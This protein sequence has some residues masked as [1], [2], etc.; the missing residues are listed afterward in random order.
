M[1]LVIVGKRGFIGSALTEYVNKYKLRSYN[2]TVLCT[3]NEAPYLTHILR[4]TVLLSST[5]VLNPVND[6][7][8]HKVAMELMSGPN[9]AIIRLSKVY[10]MDMDILKKWRLQ[11][12]LGEKI[13]AFTNRTLRPVSLNTVCECIMN[14]VKNRDVGRFECYGEE[15]LTYYDFACRNFGVWDVAAVEADDNIPI[16]K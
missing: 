5:A 14:I 12:A 6:Y 7:G 1:G 2:S 16:Y 3:H 9:V 11:I 15:E 4:H 10:G 13:T 8:R